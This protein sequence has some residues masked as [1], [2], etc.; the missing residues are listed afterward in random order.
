MYGI[1]VMSGTSVDSIDL[2]YVKISK[3]PRFES[4]NVQ[5]SKFSSLKEFSDKYKINAEVISTHEA[6]W[7]QDLKN[8]ILELV[9]EKKPL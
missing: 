2:A 5:K 1:G 7:P 4:E 9:L 8:Q 3:T 6:K